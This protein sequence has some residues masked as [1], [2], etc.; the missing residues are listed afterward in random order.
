MKGELGK[1]RGFA[2]S[3]FTGA[4]I[5]MSFPLGAPLAVRAAGGH[6]QAMAFLERIHAQFVTYA[7]AGKGRAAVI[8]R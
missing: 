5:Q 4:D 6:S 1:K 7:R 2:G 3:E 8:G